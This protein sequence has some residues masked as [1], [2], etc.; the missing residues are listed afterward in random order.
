MDKN[1]VR[2]KEVVDSAKNEVRLPIAAVATCPGI[3]DTLVV[4]V[5]SEMMR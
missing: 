5:D 4:S 3:N 2:F 1:L